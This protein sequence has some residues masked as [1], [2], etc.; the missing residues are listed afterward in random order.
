MPA[1]MTTDCILIED[2]ADDVEFFDYAVSRLL[3]SVNVKS[4]NRLDKAIVSLTNDE[5]KPH[6]IFVDHVLP[7]IDGEMYIRGLRSLKSLT[8][9][10]LI[11]L[12]SMDP[13]FIK[14]KFNDDLIHDFLEKQTSLD[15]LTAMLHA[16][17]ERN[18]KP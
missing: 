15:A 3:Y 1:A 18:K 9:A 5:Y 2:D 14:K 8:D 4:F 11:I 17:F 7:G 13:T 16:F 6:Y 12:S 10:P